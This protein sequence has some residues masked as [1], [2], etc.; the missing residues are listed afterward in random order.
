MS[1]NGK[2]AK[3]TRIDVEP[4][5]Q[6]VWPFRYHPVDEEWQRN[7]YLCQYGSSVS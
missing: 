5:L 2:P 3:K 1:E 7:S 6:R 4:R